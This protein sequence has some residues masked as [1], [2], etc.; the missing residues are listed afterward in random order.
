MENVHPVVRK[1]PVTGE[2]ALYVN[3]QFT[4]RIVGLKR[5]ESG[6]KLS[7]YFHVILV[8][9]D[10]LLDNI[11]KFLYDHIDKAGDLQ[12]RVKWSPGTVVLWDNR[13]TAHVCITLQ[14]FFSPLSHSIY[15][16]AIVDYGES[17][18]R[19]HGV[20]ITPQGE[21]PLPALEGLDLTI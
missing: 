14:F 13:V 8:R 1:H 9:T 21:R 16:S 15:Q 20:R 18:E 2:E 17:K 4:K 7:E 5:E 10:Y 11:L 19:R 6:E 3:K 12:A